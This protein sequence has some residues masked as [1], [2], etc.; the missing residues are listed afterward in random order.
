MKTLSI[1]IPLL[2]L[3]LLATA[4]GSE[5]SAAPTASTSPTAETT[6]APSFGISAAEGTPVGGFQGC[7][8][9]TRD[10]VAQVMGI[11]FDEGSGS[12][13]SDGVDATVSCFYSS[14]SGEIEIAYEVAIR[15]TP[16]SAGEE[17]ARQRGGWEQSVEADPTLTITEIETVGTAAFSI[18]LPADG[19][20]Q[21]VF[22]TGS[23]VMWIVVRGVAADEQLGYAEQL[24][25]LAIARL[26]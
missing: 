1:L 6:A 16:E 21:L 3:S 19:G 8:V 2:C 12:A 14:T 11:P 17:F 5:Q 23:S 10:D 25:Q 15:T 4:C 7:D 24:A 9:I 13:F 20:T 18:P 22:Q 26:G